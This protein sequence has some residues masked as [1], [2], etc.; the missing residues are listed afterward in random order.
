[1]CL[2]LLLSGASVLGVYP[3]GLDKVLPDERPKGAKEISAL[4]LRAA[5][6]E[7]ETASFV[8]APD[9][10]IGAFD[11]RPE[12]LKG[13]GGTIPAAA[14]DV[15]VVKVWF[16]PRD[17]WFTERV[18]GL[19]QGDFRLA[20]NMLLH[21]D[22]LVR[23]DETNKVN[24][25]RVGYPD[26]TRYLDMRRRGRLSKFNYDTEPVR[27]APRFVPCALEKNRFRQFWITVK[28]PAD[29]AA[30]DY[31]GRLVFTADGA[32]AGSLDVA[33]AV[34]PF[35]LPSPRTH[36]DTSRKYYCS[37]MN[38]PSLEALVANSHDVARSERKLRAMCR[39][40]VAHNVLNPHGPGDVKALDG[41]DFA[42]RS[43]VIWREEGLPCDALFGGRA[44]GF[45]QDGYVG[46]P[47]K[48]PEGYR[49]ETDAHRE[50]VKLQLDGM[51]RVL[52]HRNRFFCGYD[53]ASTQAN[54]RQL[55]CWRNIKELGGR[56][57]TTSA[58]PKEMAWVVDANDVPAACD[59]SVAKA[60]HAAGALAFN[61]AAPFAGVTCPEVWR[62]MQGLR[63]YFADFDGLNDLA[64]WCGDNRWNDLTWR[65]SEYQ[66]M[67]MVYP[68]EDGVID[69][70]AY[71]A[72]REAIDDIRYLSLHRLLAEKAGANDELDWVDAVDP[73]DVGDL[74]AFRREVADRCVRL[75][76]KTGPLPPE[77]EPPAAKMKLAPFAG[78]VEPLP[79]NRVERLKSVEAK[80]AA[81]GLSRAARA[82]LLLE[83]LEA[84][85]TDL[86]FEEVYT[87]AQLADAAK[88][89]GEMMASGATSEMLFR[90][91]RCQAD[92][93]N[94]SGKP[95]PAA[96]L[97]E[98]LLA[99]KPPLPKEMRGRLSVIAA[100]AYLELGECRKAI[101]AC[102]LA[103][104][105][106]PLYFPK[107]KVYG[108]WAD[109]ADRLPDL[110]SAEEAY[111]KLVKTLDPR[112]QKSD[113]DNCKRRIAEISKALRASS[114]PESAD[115]DQTLDLDE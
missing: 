58:D 105:L 18:Y 81:S 115:A 26:G 35:R 94:R 104:E 44:F 30:G 102:R 38:G 45:M 5:Q 95:K 113:Y 50:Y 33:L 2:S 10:D 79:P 24:Y 89:L 74:D 28:V 4:E 75:L 37:L 90:G 59:A 62:R 91:A 73:E 65:G 106:D 77:R 47:E 1:M 55:E 39:S 56:I 103:E 71:D 83:K 19:A 34:Y 88:T 3:Y 29:A 69:T 112:E 93:C 78:K 76:A 82:A 53:E 7:Y 41:D 21:D 110:K 51:E 36:Y 46:W 86:V 64:W 16:Q 49:K 99:Q 31:R 63:F 114:A 61:Y 8:Y 107:R 98:K 109:A 43:L 111:L 87:D 9:R 14:V 97:V 48:D 60:W 67:G 15:K 80:L 12:D 23:V 72:L 85:L 52:G 96:E 11:I 13:P 57:F 92:A 70:L 66:Q 68:T 6:D 42:L 22:S 40:L 25:L 108:F 17:A 27:D 100:E 54:R 20:P 84:Q 101:A 32:A